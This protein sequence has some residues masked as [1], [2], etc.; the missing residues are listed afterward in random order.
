MD[1]WSIKHIAAAHV[2]GFIIGNRAKPIKIANIGNSRLGVVAFWHKRCLGA[3]NLSSNYG[4]LNNV[5]QLSIWWENCSISFVPSGEKQVL[6]LFQMRENQIVQKNL[7]L[8]LKRGIV[9][10]R[11]GHGNLKWFIR[12]TL[13]NG[14]CKV[15]MGQPVWPDGLFN[16]CQQQKFA[17]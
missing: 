3:W 5:L 16:F 1:F 6:F 8:V 4:L 12:V 15:P 11:L 13:Q 2:W 14:I 7:K 17:Q 10:K 9:K